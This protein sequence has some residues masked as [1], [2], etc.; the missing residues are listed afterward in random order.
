MINRLSSYFG[1]LDNQ[2]SYRDYWAISTETDTFYVTANE[3]K[4]VIDTLERRWSPRWITFTEL[5]GATIRIRSRVIECVW[6]SSA[7][8]RQA[9]RDFRRALEEEQNVD[10]HPW[11]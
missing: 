8:H 1:Q 4:R 6:E 9:G 10:R 2:K 5:F 7:E 3:A 11:D